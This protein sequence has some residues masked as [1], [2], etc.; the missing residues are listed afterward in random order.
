MLTLKKLLPAL[1]LT[2]VAGSASAAS[3]SASSGAN[4][5]LPDQTTSIKVCYSGKQ[6]VLC[7]PKRRY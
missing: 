1:A 3:P 4:T 5:L 2:I 6:R 7:P